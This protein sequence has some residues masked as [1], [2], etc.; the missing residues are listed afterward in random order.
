LLGPDH[1]SITTALQNLGVV[2][3]ERKDY[4]AALASYGRALSIR[5]R[6]NC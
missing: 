1:Y 3:R 4:P 2:A 6:R 5:E